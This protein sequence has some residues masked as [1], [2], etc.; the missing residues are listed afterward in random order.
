MKVSI[1]SFSII[2]LFVFACSENKDRPFADTN[3]SRVS[4]LVTKINELADSVK[5]YQVTLSDQIPPQVIQIPNQAGA[6]SSYLNDGERVILEPPKVMPLLVLKDENGKEIKNDKGESYI[7]GE[8]GMAQFTT[9]TS[10]DG[11]A[12]DAVNSSLMDSR[13][14]LWFGTSG[15][16][17][18]HY[19]GTGFTNYSTVQGL[20]ANNLRSIIEDQH[21]NLWFG[22]VGGGAS[23][24]DGRSFT[25]YNT[26]NGLPDDVVFIIKEDRNGN[27]WFGTNGGGV[28]KF[29]GN[30]FQNFTTEDGL[31]GDVVVSIEE[32]KDGNL[33]FGTY[34]NGVSKYDGQTFT[35]ITTADGLAGDRVRVIFKDSKDFLW[36]GTVGDGVSRYNGNAFVNFSIEDGLASDLVRFI[37]EDREGNI[38]FAT[39]GGGISRYDG[40]T[41]TTYTNRQGLAG[42][43]VLSITEDRAG[44]LW[45]GTDGG[46]IS[47]YDGKGFTTYTTVQGLPANIIMTITEDHNHNL[48]FG[49]ANGGVSKFDG[50]SF[51]NF[52]TS[53][54]LASDVVYSIHENKD[55]EIWIGGGGGIS[56]YDGKSFTN[57]TDEQGLSA[58]DVFSILED[59]KGILWIGTDGGGI[60]RFDGETFT[61][62]TPDQGL[63]GYAI[64]SIMEDR[65]G[66][67]WFGAADGG[68]SVYDGSSFTNLTSNQG[69]IDNGVFSLEEDPMGNIWVGTEHGLSFLSVENLETLLNSEDTPEENPFLNFTSAEGL[70]NDVILQ[71]TSMPD[72]KIAI[73]TNLGIALFDGPKEGEEFKELKNLEL[74]NSNTGYPV[75]DLTDGQNGMFL[76]SK[77]IL[78]AGTGS[79]KTALSRFNYPAL[80]KNQSIP[81]VEIKQIRIN[82]EA[83]SWNLLAQAASNPE[84]EAITAPQ[85][86]EEVSTFGRSL[87]QR[88]REA[89]RERFS[90]IRFDSITLFHPIPQ[91]LVLPYR[92]NHLNIDF[93]SNEV[94]KPYLV[95]FRYMLEG[96]DQEWSPI[97]KKSSA[98]FG[99]IQEGTYTFKVMA[100]Y[101][102]PADGDAGKWTEP[103]SYTFTVL[104]PWYRSWW[105]YLIY[106]LIF[107]S[108]IYPITRYQKNQVLKA[109]QKKARERELE[110]AREI[111][112]AYSELEASH[113]NLKETQSQ[114]IQAEKMASLG[115][116][117]AGIAHEIQNPL[118]F[119]NNFSDVSNELM[120]EMMEELDNGDLEETKAIAAD[121]KDNLERINMHGKRADSI[122]KAMLQHSRVGSG[123]KEPTNINAL[124]DECL[125]LSYHGVKAKDK[126]FNS[127]FKT[128]F[129]ESIPEMNVIQQDLG[130]VILNMVSNSFYAVNEK[131]KE[132]GE[133][134]YSPCV[135]VSTK[136]ILGGIEITISDNGPG[137]PKE[138]INK[139]FQPF[140]TT[141]PTGKGTGLGLSLSYDIV[142]SHNGDLRVKSST[143]EDQG[144]AFT[145]YLPE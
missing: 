123:K 41:F 112:K 113:E 79:N 40:N 54:G 145:I 61:S 66:R 89:M 81:E 47:R 99:N 100:R 144:T 129:D 137:I 5:P 126:T 26:S 125:R 60:S 30:S 116:L 19:D 122:V 124:A 141:K 71:I 48:W 6:F 130:R 23:K 96:Y 14:H 8:G 32:D 56:L 49:T 84:S 77:G 45:F 86:T 95:E 94:S 118:N 127:D 90:E 67:I 85:I 72:Q 55:G 53:Q 107:L 70:P 15:G 139:I 74:F 73:G 1:F 38:W 106:T 134:N 33:W 133:E 92:N 3:I 105:A 101:T 108:L 83:V 31:A 111:E 131:A 39:S 50:K 75:K 142:K 52:T 135:T 63:A 34:G 114:L 87:G 76:D 115:E 102:G 117:T 93:A 37:E 59:S 28:S 82:E 97:L 43:N 91:N 4:P 9:Y 2:I 128:D 120:D 88:E 110:H 69:L 80:L 20:A 21:G 17:V 62:Y 140:F 65:K 136:H 35:S 58:N 119:V 51:T 11:L 36:F 16:G 104:P 22:T 24:F 78:W 13:G 27:L 103:I 98:T 29:D 132:L 138:I 44:K 57:Y 10:D 109:E 143:E 64:L 68:I 42:N 7:L 46:G 25:N 18:S 12:L 121:I